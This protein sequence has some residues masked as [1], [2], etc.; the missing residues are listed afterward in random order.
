MKEEGTFTTT[1]L[2]KEA[3]LVVC[4]KQDDSISK[5]AVRWKAY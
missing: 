5:M 2:Y 4:E 1:P 3:K